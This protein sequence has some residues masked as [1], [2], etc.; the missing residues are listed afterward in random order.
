M[1]RGGEVGDLINDGDGGGDVA[2]LEMRDLSKQAKG[3]EGG[4]G[5]AQIF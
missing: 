2:Y 5:R 3:E 4:E 1:G